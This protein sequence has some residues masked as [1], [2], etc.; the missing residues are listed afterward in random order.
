[1]GADFR[2]PPRPRSVRFTNPVSSKRPSLRPG[3]SPPSHGGAV[4][5]LRLQ[6]L[7]TFLHLHRTGSV[8]ALAREIG[9]SPSQVS[10]A[11]ARLEAVLHVRLFTRGARGVALSPAGR[12]MLP[13][14]EQM[15]E[16]ARALGR[17]EK[18]PVTELT[19]AAP[20]SLLPPILPRVINA[21]PLTRVRGIELPST[22]LRG[23][24]A[25]ELFDV[26]LLSGGVTG[27][28]TKWVSVRIGEFRKSLLASPVLAKK[29]GPRPTLAQ[30][31]AEAFVGPIA[32]DG[33]KYVPSTD[34]CPLGLEERTVASEVGTMAL[35]LLVASE[36][37]HLL[38]GPVIAAQRE[39]ESGALV[40]LRVPGWTVTEELFLA[41]DA[42]RV[43]ARDQ[44]AIVA[45]IR[46][47]L[48][49]VS[50]HGAGPL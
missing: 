25:E 44:T 9:V 49:D 10:K 19:I 6:D 33:G 50:T 45:A 11:V 15:V 35:A 36:C 37:G 39:I 46:E 42:E 14:F 28:P 31:R 40:E 27:L 3:A 1:V 17:A 29:L 8:T 16:L 23:Y 30:V 38:F 20:S 4:D 47:A 21:L 48:D 18:S 22:L 43:M 24:A 41:C 7:T 32:Y 34:D 2:T 13:M 26:A 5:D 12:R